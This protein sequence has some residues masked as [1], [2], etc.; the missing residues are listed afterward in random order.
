MNVLLIGNGGREHAIAAAL[1]ASPALARLHAAPGN[2]GIARHA[3]IADLDISNHAAVLAFCASHAIDL[4]VIGPE[5]P[6]AAGLVDDLAAAGVHAFGP[7]RAAAM[8]ES[9]KG[10]TKALCREAGIPTARFVLCADR[11]A[12][13]AEVEA[14]GAPIVVKAD[15]LAAG[16]GVTVAETVE[17]AWTAID[18]LFAA[19][20]TQVVIEEKLDGEEAS[21][22]VLCDGSIAL[23]FGVA[24]DHKR[25][26]EADT[27]PNT[28]GMG[29]YTPVPAVTNEITRRV[30]E[31]IV[32]PTLATMAAR[33]TPYRGIL[34][35]GVM[36]TTEGPKLIEYNCRFGDPETQA[37]LPLL[38]DD[39]LLLLRASAD[40]TLAGMSCR[41]AAGAALTVVMAAHGY[42]GPIRTGDVVTGIA[43]ARGL[44]GVHVFEAGTSV[45]P[46]GLVTARGRVLAVT[47]LGPTLPEARDR[48]YRAVD[49]ISFADAV[50]RRDIG[51]RAFR[52]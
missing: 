24:Q 21:F 51:W 50:V 45:A 49:A 22:F 52:E 28:G 25:V 48:A 6:L 46:N 12:A 27:G 15:G 20:S 38:T 40:G 31:E 19:G 11:E 41:L 2:P 13:R 23:P 5:G 36:L 8:L 4:V 16:K 30:H 33:G 3:E 7:T 39:L 1:A 42:P 17:E 47:G 43:D 9:S 35:A 10:F 44:P 37:L 29:A 18:G 34:F 26:G 32:R 14:R